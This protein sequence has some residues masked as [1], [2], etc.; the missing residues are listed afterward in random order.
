[1][2]TKLIKYALLITI[3]TL[4]GACASFH[5]EEIP[6]VESMPDVSTYEN[7]P[8]VYVDLKFFF[9]DPNNSSATEITQTKDKLKPVIEN[10]LKNSGLFSEFTFDKFKQE[11][12]D[13]T[14][15]LHFYNHG[16]MGAAAVSGF[17]TGF[18]FG[19]IPG[20]ATDNFTLKSEL[21]D[22]TSSLLALQNTDSMTTWIGIWFIPMMANDPGSTSQ[23]VLIN[24]IK[25]VISEMIEKEQLKYSLLDLLSNQATL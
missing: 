25:T 9:G 7:K 22:N 24:Q 11:E 13:Y 3:T 18:T 19:V 8:K 10:Y 6:V 12:M 17:I 16:E 5:N 4:L 15:Q 1:M 23:K 14:L 21:K 2:P 20:A